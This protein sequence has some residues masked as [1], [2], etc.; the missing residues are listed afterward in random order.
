MN[1]NKIANII[2]CCLVLGIFLI[3][4]RP[5]KESNRQNHCYSLL[6][7]VNQNSD[8]FSQVVETK[9]FN[10][11]TE[12]LLAATKG[13]VQLDSS[14]QPEEVTENLLNDYAGNNL[15]DLQV[16]IGIDWDYSNFAGSSYTWVVS[17]SGCSSSVQYR[18]SSMPSGWDNRVS[19]ARAYSNCNYYY[20]Y[21]NTNQEGSSVVCNTECSTMGSLDN[22]TSSEKWTY[23]P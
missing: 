3:A 22:A 16:V 4:A 14:I 18:V 10:S 7:P 8:D 11:F 13:R 2:L 15:T 5:S 9:C 1:R 23:T 12:S 19:S 20:H 21:Q 6:S 17:G